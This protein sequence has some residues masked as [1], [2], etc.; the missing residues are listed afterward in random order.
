MYNVTG[1]LTVSTA[2]ALLSTVG[3]VGDTGA[4]PD[5][6]KYGVLDVLMF[7]LLGLSIVLGGF[8]IMGTAIAYNCVSAIGD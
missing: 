1:L 8:S 3:K 6:N 4:D 2:V 7:L 5:H